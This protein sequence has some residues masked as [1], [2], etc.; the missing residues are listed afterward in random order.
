MQLSSRLR[1]K[2]SLGFLIRLNIHTSVLHQ[3]SKESILATK[4][5][6]LGRLPSLKGK[7]NASCWL[8]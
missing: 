6:S 8:K 1:S 3:N 2:D 7:Q 5:V 4:R